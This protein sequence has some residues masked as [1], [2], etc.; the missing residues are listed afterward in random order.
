LGVL[1]GYGMAKGLVY[2]FGRAFLFE[3]TTL[4]L[5][6]FA[7]VCAVVVGVIVTVAAALY[8]ALRAGR[9]S[10]VEA[11]RSRSGGARTSSRPLALLAPILGLALTGVGVPWIYY[12][13]K[14]LSADLDGLV[15]A[16]GIA[17]IVAAFLGVS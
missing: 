1:F 5:T 3:I 4:V 16:S 12:L 8:P 6:P 7:L 10:P 17:G 15:Y 9:V 13:A 14:N 11:M 2:L